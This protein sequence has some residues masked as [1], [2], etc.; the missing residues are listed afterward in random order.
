M[1]ICAS[2]AMRVAA[3]SCKWA[4]R[5]AGMPAL[6]QAS[7]WPVM[8]RSTCW[9]LDWAGATTVSVMAAPCSTGWPPSMAVRGMGG[10]GGVS[11]GVLAAASAA[12]PG[13]AC[14]GAASHGCKARSN[15]WASG[16][17]AQDGAAAT[18]GE[19]A[20]AAA[21]AAA[22]AVV[23]V[24]LAAPGGVTPCAE[25]AGPSCA[26]CAHCRR[27][28]SR[29]CRYRQPGRPR[30]GLARAPCLAAIGSQRCRTRPAPSVAMAAAAPTSITS[31]VVG[32]APGAMRPGPLEGPWV[33]LGSGRRMGCSRDG[34]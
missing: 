2:A 1:S 11:A 33:G 13:R 20:A 15:P 12:T 26:A 22:V 29:D 31:R 4:Q 25:Q 34:W 6:A 19:P 5:W 9:A 27:L 23:L 14:G 8:Q 28:P 32:R 30:H 17:T 21:V 3:P 24:A 18:G 10:S 7:A 16:G